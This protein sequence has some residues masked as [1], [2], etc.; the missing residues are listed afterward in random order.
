MVG[1]ETD[2]KTVSVA[3]L[4]HEKLI[5]LNSQTVFFLNDLMR[6]PAHDSL[7]DK[8]HAHVNHL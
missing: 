6:I 5:P 7:I 8:W 2:T 3:L 4:R 1:T